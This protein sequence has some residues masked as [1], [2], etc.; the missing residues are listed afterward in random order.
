MA[1]ENLRNFEPAV[2]RCRHHPRIVCGL[3]TKHSRMALAA[4][5]AFLLTMSLNSPAEPARKKV[6]ATGWDQA[7]TAEL[8]ANL[9][10]MEQQPFDGVALYAYGSVASGKPVPLHVAFG[11]QAWQRAWFQNCVDDLRACKFQKFTDNFVL[12]GANP[13]DVDWF[14]DD[15]WRA[16]VEHWRIAA[17]LAK[18]GGL[19]GLLFDPEP[20]APPF[21]Q[22]LFDTQPDKARHTFAEY[23]AQARL[24]G[25]QIMQAV[26]AEFPDIV[27]FS[28]F[29]NSVQPG[30]A[31]QPAR[32]AHEGYGLLPA[33]LD[34]WLDALPP[35]A[36]L[37]DGC[38]SSYLYNSAERFLAATVRIKGDAQQFVA[39]ENRAKYRAQVQ[40]GFGIYLD[41]YWNPPN[42]S[43]H[44]V[45]ASNETRAARLGQNV[46]AA[47]RAADE[48]VWIYGEKFRWWPTPNQNV[49]PQSWPE[50]LPGCAAELGMARD[51]NAYARECV[52]AG[53][54]R[55]VLKNGEFAAEPGKKMPDGWN[56]WQGEKSH[57]QFTWEAG[58]GTAGK[59]AARASGVHD[60]CFIQGFP[61]QPGER[62]AVQI[63]RRLQGA[64]EAWLRVRW[65]SPEGHWMLE[66]EDVLLYADGPRN[67]WREIFGAVQVPPGVGRLLVLLS[68]A[69][70]VTTN[71]VAWFSA[72]RV[73]KME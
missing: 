57:G 61:V 72:A 35:G 39:P 53:K 51:A 29:L 68:V 66:G 71:D 37:V 6:I 52:A 69:G 4:G 11:T 9:A 59:N 31:P 34:G 24:R 3:D 64:G 38:E 19:K 5:A 60:G 44:I 33:F 62:Y 1:A 21:S 70:Q 18:Q 28:Y 30:G 16:I 8:R 14:D 15:G 46:A 50:A 20:Y 56:C 10:A 55:D 43:W 32:L 40:A 22:F 41:A 48:Y 7:T 27:L 47:L 54:S 42:S 73:Y 45:A 49:R 67:V 25:R 17:W 2:R 23:Q 65:Q 12:L 13:G 58:A 26:A 36:T 63:Q